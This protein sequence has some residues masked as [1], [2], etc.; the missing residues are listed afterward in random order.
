MNR[1]HRTE[2]LLGPEAL[3]RLSRARVTVAG[4]G[5]VGS[6]A[7][8]ALARAGTG[9]LRLI[10]ADVINLT[11]INRQLFALSSTVGRAKTELAAER[12]RDINPDCKIEA[13]KTYIDSST[14]DSIL[15]PL[16]DVLI[17]AIDTLS[18][19]IGLLQR[20]LE[21]GVPCIISSMGAA[22]KTDATAVRIADLAKTKHCRLARFIRK[23]LRRRGIR[24]GITCVYSEEETG[25]VELPD[26][27][28]D[29][30][31]PSKTCDGQIRAPLG[32]TPWLP[33]IFGF[34]AAAE[35]V[36]FLITRD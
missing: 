27:I 20:A 23:R 30:E 10:D 15:T 34:T 8:E 17:D 24:T 21:L 3:E 12:V 11:N 19:K 4:L 35:A 14:T 33:P 31:P 22:N 5:G 18:P 26:E 16:P 2:L 36:R 28:P 29:F 25:R 13:F 6:Y 32:S 9:H 1:F 7:A